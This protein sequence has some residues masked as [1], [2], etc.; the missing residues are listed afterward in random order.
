MSSVDFANT[1]LEQCGIVVPP[2]TGY[3]S[4]GE[5]FFRVALT[6]DEAR[7]REALERMKTA[8]IRFD[9][10]KQAV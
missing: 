3:G 5:G 8:G 4:C 1:L 2:G 6:V 9:M 7:L 10:L